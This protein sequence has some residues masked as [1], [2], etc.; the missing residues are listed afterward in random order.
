MQIKRS[1]TKKPFDKRSIQDTKHGTVGPLRRSSLRSE[2]EKKEENK[3]PSSVKKSNDF[4]LIVPIGLEEAAQVELKE[5][6]AILSTKFGQS[7]FLLNSSIVKGGVE[8]RI[9]SPEVAFLLNS[10]LKLSSRILQRIHTFQTREWTVVEK[11]LKSVAWKDYFSEGIS[12][13]EI[14]ASESRM[15]N[16]KHLAEFLTEKF[17]NKLYY[18]KNTGNVAYLRVYNNIFTLSR[19]TS[20]EH[21]HFRGYRKH[22]GEAPLRETLAAFLWFFLIRNR[23]RIETEKAL[24]ID[25]FVGSGTILI[26]AMLWNQVIQNRK[27]P[28]MDW[29]SKDNYLKFNSILDRLTSWNLNLIGIDSD[30]EAIK[31]AQLNLENINYSGKMSLFLGDST[32]LNAELSSNIAKLNRNNEIWLISNPPYGGKGRIKTHSTWKEVGSTALHTYQPNWAVALGP[33]RECRTDS[34]IGDW[35]CIETQKF[36]NGGIRVVASLWKR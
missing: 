15:N 36:L 6:C 1:Q 33:E 10:C 4:F 11:E 32:N 34:V 23:S 31:K 24:I 2:N 20:G 19:D 14:S 28:S 7:A 30:K 22:Q 5:W 25:P 29:V 18:I 9:G 27:F 12:E 26:E 35:K 21:L 8:F 17:E 13:W 16:E 3:S